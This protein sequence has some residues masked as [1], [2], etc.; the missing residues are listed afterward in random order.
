MPTPPAHFA[1]EIA[2]QESIL[3]AL[4]PDWRQPPEVRRRSGGFGHL[5][6][7]DAE[8][9]KRALKIR[10]LR[11]RGRSNGVIT[12]WAEKEGRQV[13][14]VHP[15]PEGAVVIDTGKIAQLAHT[16]PDLWASLQAAGV[17]PR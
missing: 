11:L 15:A 10:D 9:V 14:Y 8:R 7:L 17:V 16:H 12:T 13:P 3:D 4:Y 2:E 5:A 1:A 6:P